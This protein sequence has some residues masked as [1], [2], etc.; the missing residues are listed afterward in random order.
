MVNGVVFK[1]KKII[2]PIIII[3]IP[4]WLPI[5]NYIF[6]TIINAGRIIGTSIRIIN[7]NTICLF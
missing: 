2:I 1:S 4:I 5:I 6:E 7:S 3:T